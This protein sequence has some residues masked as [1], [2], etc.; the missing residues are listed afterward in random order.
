MSD[1][2]NYDSM[3]GEQSED[4]SQ[5]AENTEGTNDQAGSDT[6][7][8]DAE[9]TSQDGAETSSEAGDQGAGQQGE[10]P[11]EGGEKPVE[12]PKWLYQA[13]KDYQNDPDLQDKSK[14]DDLIADYKRLKSE[15]AKAEPAPEQ[16]ELEGDFAEEISD[17][18]DSF[19]RN[20]AKELGLSQEQAQQFFNKYGEFFAKEKTR[21]SETRR[22]QRADAEEKLR[23]E[24][25]G[26]QYNEMIQGVKT[27]VMG[28]APEGLMETLR[29]K[30]LDN[31]PLVV[32][33]LSNVGRSLGEDKLVGMGSGSNSRQESGVSAFEYGEDFK[34][35]SSG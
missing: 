35:M 20:T 7:S 23:K 19:F 32:Q 3:E 16:Y 30:E 29:E 17:Q 2:L 10:A 26:A 8:V 31:D 18:F 5:T 27:A 11:A 34:K 1:V 9:S 15:S 13:S 4:T 22:Q 24:F 33:W 12:P 6:Q 21:L 28:L 14:I 25:P